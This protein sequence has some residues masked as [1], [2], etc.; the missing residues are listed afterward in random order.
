MS[1]LGPIDSLQPYPWT[2]EVDFTAPDA[3]EQYARAGFRC[4][5]GTETEYVD[6]N[7]VVRKAAPG[8]PVFEYDPVTGRALGLRCERAHNNYLHN[9]EN[10]NAWASWFGGLPGLVK[11][12]ADPAGG[13]EAWSFRIGDL[14]QGPGAPGQLSGGIINTGVVVPPENV[15]HTGEVWIRCDAVRQFGFGFSDAAETYVATPQWQKFKHTNIWSSAKDVGRLFQLTFFY[16]TLSESGTTSPDIRFYIWHPW[17]WQGTVGMSYVKSL[18]T[19][20]YA[21]PD[22]HACDFYPFFTGYNAEGAF[23]IEWQRKGQIVNAGGFNGLFQISTPGPAGVYSYHADEV[24][25]DNLIHMIQYWNGNRA[26]VIGPHRSTGQTGGHGIQRMGFAW[27]KSGGNAPGAAINGQPYKE[28]TGPEA[29]SAGVV[30]VTRLMLGTRWDADPMDGYIRKIRFH[31]N[32]NANVPKDALP[33]TPTPQAL[34]ELT[35]DRFLSTS[36]FVP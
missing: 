12:A 4:Q 21:A 8:V 15:M 19:A 33:V 23:Y 31:R 35:N 36:D 25:T 20:P 14:P 27:Y 16:D 30:G 1:Y 3:A 6:S 10:L 34:S 13:N 5:R 26:S 28:M 11:G 2:Y 17:M 7:L 22:W 29:V 9:S 32:F 18:T 24:P